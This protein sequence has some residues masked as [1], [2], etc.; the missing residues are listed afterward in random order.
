MK[1]RV[2]RFNPSIRFLLSDWSYSVHWQLAHNCWGF[3]PTHYTL[4]QEPRPKWWIKT[5][6]SHNT[7]IRQLTARTHVFCR[8]RKVHWLTYDT[9]VTRISPV[10]YL[11]A[12]LRAKTQLR[13]QCQL[14]N[15]FQNVRHSPFRCIMGTTYSCASHIIDRHAQ[16]KQSKHAQCFVIFQYICERDD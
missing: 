10:V 16:L 14:S 13:C 8:D 15:S 2:F 7:W 3:E 9:R 11:C 12:S 5:F 4:W 6:A 1:M